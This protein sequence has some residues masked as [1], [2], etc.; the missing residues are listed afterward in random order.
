[1]VCKDKTNGT[2]RLEELYLDYCEMEESCF[3]A[4]AKCLPFLK[5][6][7]L[8]SV[9][10]L[11]LK[12]CELIKNNICNAAKDSNLVLENIDL[13]YSA[14]GGD[15]LVILADCIPYL[16]IVNLANNRGGSEGYKALSNKIYEAAKDGI[17]VTKQLSL[18]NYNLTTD[19]TVMLSQCLPY[20]QMVKL[21]GRGVS[22]FECLKE[23]NDN[24]CKTAKDRT[25]VLEKLE[26]SH[27]ARTCDGSGLC[28]DFL[29]YLKAVDLSGNYF[30]VDNC[31]ILKDTILDAAKDGTLVLQEII[32]SK[33]SLT[34][35]KLFILADC[36][37]YLK[38]VDI[39]FNCHS[40]LEGVSAV[41]ENIKATPMN[42]TENGQ[43]P[44]LQ[45]LNLY[46]SIAQQEQLMVLAEVLPYIKC[47]KLG[48]EEL[49]ELNWDEFVEAF[50]KTS[51]FIC[52]SQF[53]LET[54]VVPE[55]CLSGK[56]I[57]SLKTVHPDLEI[58]LLAVKPVILR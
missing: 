29:R 34:K 21:G 38:M 47:V 18:W 37:P 41:K 7:S 20:V 31:K 26:I 51:K 15:C 52:N 40:G 4:I 54:I 58:R 56:S 8:R 23:L 14:L 53:V 46:S 45:H 2:L 25:L 6:V 11:G 22:H 9:R 3:A 42:A 5:V 32:L 19:E 36:I 55:D 12:G 28:T 43:N 24:I 13:S 50:K 17:L 33:C 35:E 44:K 16:K 10:G 39:S 1:M 48:G 30:T 27:Y 49:K 57:H